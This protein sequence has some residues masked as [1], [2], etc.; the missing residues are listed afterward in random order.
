MLPAPMSLSLIV[1]VSR[2]VPAS[3]IEDFLEKKG[4]DVANASIALDAVSASYELIARKG[5]AESTI[6]RV[7]GPVLV[8]AE[9]LD[10]K[11]AAMLL[12]PRYQY[13]ISFSAELSQPHVSALQAFGAA[14]AKDGDG[15][16]GE[17]GALA[18]SAAEAVRHAA[19]RGARPEAPHFTVPAGGSR[20]AR[21]DDA[22]HG[23]LPAHAARS[24]AAAL[25]VVRAAPVQSERR[26]RRAEADRACRTARRARVRGV[27][28]LDVHPT[29]SIT[30]RCSL[31]IE[32]ASRST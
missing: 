10:E 20:C 31:R 5:L 15:A 17:C 28:D 19:R 7:D 9:D 2:L 11:L 32:G 24:D 22:V 25:R 18:R 13:E 6:A 29:R 16:T 4:L 21:V 3:K 26:G 8:E 23:E 30:E 27:F 12:A 14:L 1:A